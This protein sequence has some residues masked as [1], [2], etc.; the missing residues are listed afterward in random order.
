[1]NFKLR[2]EKEAITCKKK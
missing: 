1:M 2:E